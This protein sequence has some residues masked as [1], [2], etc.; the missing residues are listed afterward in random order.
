MFALERLVF[1]SEYERQFA[2]KWVPWISRVSCVIPIPSNIS[3]FEGPSNRSLDEILYF[4]LIVPK[5]GLENVIALGQLIKASG[6]SFRIRIVGSCPAKHATYF[7]EMRSKTATLPIVWDKDLGE[8]QVAQR[9]ASSSIAYLPY[10]DGVSERRASFKAALLNGVTVITTRGKHTPSSL[11]GFVTFCAN[12]EE[13]LVAVRSLM[14]ND[15]HRTMLADKARHYAGQFSWDR[16]AEAHLGL[17]E[18]LM[19]AKR[20]LGS[21]SRLNPAGESGIE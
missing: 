4:G 14:Q 8:G 10:P 15:G 2:V 7:E 20:H 6:L 11:E 12:P 13:A 3:A 19:R 9:L 21:K 17:Y 5:K 16:I 18:N 1:T